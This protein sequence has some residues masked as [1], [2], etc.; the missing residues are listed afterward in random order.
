MPYSGDGVI[1]ANSARPI[2]APA[3]AYAS[4]GESVR[5]MWGGLA[6]IFPRSWNYGTC[7]MASMASVVGPPVRIRHP[8]TAA[9]DLATIMRTV[10]DP[11]RLPVGRGLGGG[12]GGGGGGRRSAPGTP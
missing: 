5:L 10:G 3:S 12:G 11:V 7:I 1:D 4:R 6:S 9:I 8:E 2:T